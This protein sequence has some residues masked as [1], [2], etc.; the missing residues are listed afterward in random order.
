MNIT[1]KSSLPIDLQTFGFVTRE[2]EKGIPVPNR[3][4]RDFLYYCLHYYLRETYSPTTLD[5]KR[6]EEERVFGWCI[7]SW[8]IWTGLSF[9]KVPALLKKHGLELRINRV[10]IT[11]W[12]GFLLAT[13]GRHRL[14]FEEAVTEVKLAIDQQ[15]VSGIDISIRMKG[16]IDHVMFVYAYDEDGLCVFDTHFV[17]EAG[18]QKLTRDNRCIMFL[19]Y[20]EISKRWTGLGRVWTI[21][22]TGSIL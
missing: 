19:P 16:L 10:A 8:L 18:Y 11:S 1:F 20:R 6:I 3:C 13:I 7:P 21:S 12:F 22:R 15:R 17:R 9:V 5:P 4:G 14:S 2:S